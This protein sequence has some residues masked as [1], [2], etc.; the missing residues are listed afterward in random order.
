MAINLSRLRMSALRCA[1]LDNLDKF[2]SRAGYRFANR[3]V[4]EEA[5]HQF[6]QLVSHNFRSV[7]N[8]IVATENLEPTKECAQKIK[9]QFPDLSTRHIG[10]MLGVSHMTIQR[11]LQK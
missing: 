10:L 5:Q 11:W 6:L 3:F 7:D 9:D 4:I 8:L 1:V 2:H